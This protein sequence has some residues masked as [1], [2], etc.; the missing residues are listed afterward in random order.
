MLVWLNRKQLILEVIKGVL[1]SSWGLNVDGLFVDRA[2]VK[3]IIDL[4]PLKVPH[5]FKIIWL[6][7]KH[8]KFNFKLTKSNFIMKQLQFNLSEIN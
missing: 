1:H 7:L 3:L 6:I 8:K 5:R 4:L 2:S